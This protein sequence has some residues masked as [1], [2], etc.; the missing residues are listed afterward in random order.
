MKETNLERIQREVFS[1]DTEAGYRLRYH[2]TRARAC[3]RYKA[4]IGFSGVKFAANISY[5]FI[6]QATT[7]GRDYWYAIYKGINNR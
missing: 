1:Y 7:E 6:F 3:K 5:L 2:I 4:E